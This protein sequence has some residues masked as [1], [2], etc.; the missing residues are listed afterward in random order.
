MIVINEANSYKDYTLSNWRHLLEKNWN[1]LKQ[2][3]GTANIEN[4]IEH[5]LK[6][7]ISNIS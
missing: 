5:L 3:N 7:V 1:Y 6:I 2:D 4:I